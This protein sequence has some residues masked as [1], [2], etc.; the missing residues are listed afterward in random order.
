M[1]VDSKNG[2][3]YVCGGKVISR[4]CTSPSYSGLY[5]Y[6]IETNEWDILR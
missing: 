2:I 1:C 5:A 4:D 6:K 3:I